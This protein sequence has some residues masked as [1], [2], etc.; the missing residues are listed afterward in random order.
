MFATF[1]EIIPGRVFAGIR[2]SQTTELSQQS[3]VIKTC[4]FLS[5]LASA[6]LPLI[7]TLSAQGYNLVRMQLMVIKQEAS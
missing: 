2:Y 3:M 4:E 6:C 7:E 5:K 1:N